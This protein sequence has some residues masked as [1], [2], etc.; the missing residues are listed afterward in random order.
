MT[1]NNQTQAT[2]NSPLANHPRIAIVLTAVGFAGLCALELIPAGKILPPLL[3][4]FSL[5]MVALCL[6]PFVLGLPNGRKAFQEYCRDIRLLPAQPLARN[7]LLG[8]LLALLTLAS[9]FL[10]SLL[11]GHFAIDWSTIPALRWVKGLTRGIWEE[12]FFRGIILALFMRLYPRRRAVLL[13]AFLF[14]MMHLSVP[15]LEVAV[16][17]ISLFFMGLLFVYVVLKTGSLLPAIIFHYVHDVFVNWVQ[18]TPGA[19]N[20]LSSALLYGFLWVALIVGALLTKL[21][22]ERWSGGSHWAVG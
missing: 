1:T 18:N 11:T 15:S 3:L 21:I 10:A 22:V 20:V 14:A 2:F 17:L 13:S 8:L 4:F 12:V 7:I 6:M 9:I 5:G 19:D 16:D